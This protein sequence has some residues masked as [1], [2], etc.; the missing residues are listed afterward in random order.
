MVMLG[1]ETQIGLA[2]L[3]SGDGPLLRRFFFRLSPATIYR[4]FMSPIQRPEQAHPERL[5]DLDH[6]EREAIC[7]V[8]G[9]EIV[10]IARYARRAGFEAADLAVVVADA[11]QRQGVATRMLGAL[12]ARAAGAGIGR[13]QATMHADNLAAV[14]LLRRLQPGARL[15]LSNGI[16]ETSFSISGAA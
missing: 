3:E 8:A 1:G 6:R 5:L 12:A 2:Q 9:G 16:Y 14:A 15:S 11:W 4:R 7:A 13:F 10:G